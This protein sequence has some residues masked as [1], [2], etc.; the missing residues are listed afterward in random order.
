MEDFTTAEMPNVKVREIFDR[1]KKATANKVGW[2]EIEI[3][4]NGRRAVISTGISL[5]KDQW[6]RGHIVGRQD[7][8]NLNRQIET[9]KYSIIKELDRQFHEDHRIDI[10]SVRQIFVKKKAE[11]EQK[12]TSPDFLLFMQKR[13]NERPM[14]EGTWKQHRS[15]YHALNKLGKIKTFQDL[16][17]AN[18]L[19]WDELSRKH[20]KNGDS[21]ETW[22]KCLK[23]YV[24]EA[25][26]FGHISKDNNPY[27]GFKIKRDRSVKHAFLTQAELNKWCKV[28]LPS[29]LAE[30]ARD[31]FVF[32]CYTGLSYADLTNFDT[33]LIFE[34]NGGLRYVNDRVKSEETFHI[35][36][37]KPA[38]K[39]LDKY[40]WELPKMDAHVY[41]RYLKD[42]AL[43]C[44][45]TKTIT[46]HCGRCT[47]ASTVLLA[48]GFGLKTIANAMG[49]TNTRQTEE[50]AKLVSSNVDRSFDEL[51]ARL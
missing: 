44:G 14:A 32:C 2:V 22:H 27:D 3:Y 29:K 50:Y 39:I 1:K 31:L 15:V 9:T 16:T 7:S 20:S 23:V 11:E 42:I 25:I 5:Y 38:K 49:H 10:N 51:N 46:S 4:Y 47:F 19:L 37:L 36:I 17:P 18:I 43:L 41:N 21:I 6:K 48:N 45:I 40:N 26:T 8:I 33:S 35:T 28:K 13:M 30:T 34:D 12:Q 24:R